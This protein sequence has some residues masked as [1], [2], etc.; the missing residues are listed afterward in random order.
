MPRVIIY[1][2]RG[3]KEAEGEVPAGMNLLAALQQLGAKH[4]SPAAACAPAPPA[5]AG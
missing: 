2:P 1:D 4:G 3:A 5:T